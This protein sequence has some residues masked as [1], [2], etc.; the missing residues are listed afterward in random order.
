MNRLSRA[1][2]S[3]Q[4]N[5]NN[6]FLNVARRVLIEDERS[7]NRHGVGNILDLF[8]VGVVVFVDRL[9]RF[10]DEIGGDKEE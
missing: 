5:C 4:E 1:V 7:E 6:G 3:R 9:V 10:C 2:K 8:L